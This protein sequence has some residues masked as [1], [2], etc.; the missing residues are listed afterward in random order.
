MNWKP[1]LCQK[2]VIAA[3]AAAL[4][5]DSGTALAKGLLAGINPWLLAGLL[6]W[7]PVVRLG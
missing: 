7:V 2:G 5:F 4:L 3:L 6:Y 1:G